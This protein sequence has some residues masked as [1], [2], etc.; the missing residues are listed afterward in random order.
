[1]IVNTMSN[2]G[3]MVRAA[4]FWRRIGRSDGNERLLVL[5]DA[6]PPLPQNSWMRLPEYRL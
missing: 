5:V 3:L 4:G 6:S 2:N 1:M